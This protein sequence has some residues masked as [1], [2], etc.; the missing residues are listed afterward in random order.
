M[1]MVIYMK[2]LVTGNGFDLA[3]GLPTTYKDMLTALFSPNK[4]RENH[5][6]FSLD[7]LTDDIKQKYANVELLNYFKSQNNLN[8]WTGFENDLQMIIKYFSS[9]PPHPKLGNST[10]CGDLNSYKY[11]ELKSIIDVHSWQKKDQNYSKIMWKKLSDQLNLVCKFIDL[12]IQ[13]LHTD[14]NHVPEKNSLTPIYTQEYNCYLTFN[15]SN[16]FQNCFNDAVNYFSPS[17]SSIPKHPS[18]QSTNSIQRVQ[19]I[20]GKSGTQ[21]IQTDGSETLSPLVLGIHNDLTQIDST[22]NQIYQLRFEKSFQRIQ[23]QT[24]REF[25]QWFSPQF[26]TSGTEISTT[27]YGHSLDVADHDVIKFI[28]EKSSD[29]T[30]YYLDQHDYEQKIVNLI[31]L[32]NSVTEVEDRFYSGKITFTPIPT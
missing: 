7:W 1:N 28:I 8:G 31:K 2:L 13:N 24:G 14:F 18:Q 25:R 19:F 27:I 16:T 26:V 5:P 30:I 15:Y 20:H 11:K 32:Y 29:T 6:H 22:D 21:E 4:F 23:K 17:S 10:P 9:E 12:Y 3:H